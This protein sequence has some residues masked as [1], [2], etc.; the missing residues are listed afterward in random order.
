MGNGNYAQ[1]I[2][3]TVTIQY[4]IFGVPNP[5]EVQE[6][7]MKPQLLGTLTT[8]ENDTL[9]KLLQTR[10]N[11]KSKRLTSAS[12]GSEKDLKQVKNE[13]GET[14]TKS[15]DKLPHML[16]CEN[17]CCMLYVVLSLL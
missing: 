13:L 12:A 10:L 5:L 6:Q 8:D 16:R 3:R 11:T 1:L 4:E 17:V 14:T 15:Q 7:D 9:D 2:L